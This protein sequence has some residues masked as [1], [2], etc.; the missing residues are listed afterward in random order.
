MIRARR[1]KIR[2]QQWRIIFGRPP[3]NKCSALCDYE[4]H[5]IYIRKGSNKT[6][7]LVHECLHAMFPDLSED[8]IEEAERTIVKG[9]EII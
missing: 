4:T 8:V 7:C 6:E 3:A 5:T 1:L 2:G 9:L